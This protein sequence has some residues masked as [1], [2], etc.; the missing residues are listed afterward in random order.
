MF[1]KIIGFFRIPYSG[2]G[3]YFYRLFPF[4]CRWP[5]R[6]TRGSCPIMWG[7]KVVLRADS[8]SITGKPSHWHWG[9]IE[10]V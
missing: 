4:V 6:F 1:K 2:G 5:H 3:G 9:W 8:R 7:E 10:T